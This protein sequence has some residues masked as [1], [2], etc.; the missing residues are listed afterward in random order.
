M[1]KKSVPVYLQNWMSCSEFKYVLTVYVCIGAIA[2]NIKQ[3]VNI[4]SKP[5]PKFYCTVYFCFILLLL[6]NLFVFFPRQ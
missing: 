1:Q 3:K 5:N 2:Y 4:F 6:H